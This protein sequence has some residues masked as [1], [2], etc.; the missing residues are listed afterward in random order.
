MYGTAQRGTQRAMG[1]SNP[2]FIPL[3]RVIGAC[4]FAKGKDGRL[5][6]C[7]AGDLLDWLSEAQAEHFLSHGLV[8]RI[9]AA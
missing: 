1:T 6:Q 3:W 7:L 4:V 9:D 2:T 8:E 5:R